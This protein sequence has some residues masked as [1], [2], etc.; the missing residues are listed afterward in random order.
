MPLAKCWS[1]RVPS[2]NPDALRKLERIINDKSKVFEY[3]TGGSTIWL[4]KR[5][6]KLVSVEH[7]RDWFRVLREGIREDFGEI[8][9]N[10]TLMLRLNTPILNDAWVES[11]TTKEFIGMNYIDSILNYPDGYFDLV[12]VDGRARMSCLFN[13]RFKVKKAGF[14]LLDDSQRQCYQDGMGMMEDWE[15]FVCQG[16]D[17]TEYQNNQTTFFRRSLDNA[18]L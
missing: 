7:N 3:G 15:S 9:K 1:K 8:P 16:R 2:I 13:S 18:N 14:L 4:A 11:E 5:V 12:I 10:L 17:N 6:G